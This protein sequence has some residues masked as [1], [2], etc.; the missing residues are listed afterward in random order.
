MVKLK[1]KLCLL[2]S[3]LTLVSM[4]GCAEKTAD[5]TQQE[6]T[7]TESQVQ[8][9]T[10][11]TSA[12]EQSGNITS[13]FNI[14]STDDV[15]AFVAQMKL[16][17][18]ASQMVQ[19]AGYN[20]DQSQMEDYCYGSVLSTWQGMDSTFTGWKKLTMG[21]QQSA[22][23][24]EVGIPYIY[25][26]DAVHGVNQCQDAVIFP[27]NIGIGA[28]NDEELTYKMG[29][30][31]ADEMKLTGMLMNFSPCVAVTQDPRWGRTYESYSSDPLLVM[32][33]GTVYTKGLADNG[34]LVC[35]KHFVGDGNVKFGTGEG[36]FLIDRG[37]AD[38]KCVKKK[39]ANNA[40]IK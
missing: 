28:A 30:I 31:V 39:R 9:E 25:G 18:K 26:T 17:D 4:T 34:I 32:K 11:A 22:L 36:D 7:T 20:I 40:C 24:S 5:I 33:L 23:D 14:K 8:Q 15:K 13:V 27:H 37:D 38:G 1:R 35:A 21:L 3:I 19:G 16:E 10:S 29:E 6:K 12:P 2:L